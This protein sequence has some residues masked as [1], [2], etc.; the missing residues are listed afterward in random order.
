MYVQ[1]KLKMK[2]LIFVGVI[3]ICCFCKLAESDCP[4]NDFECDSGACIKS[5]LVC[6]GRPD[7][8][9]N[10]DENIDC[11]SYLCRP[12]F[13]YKCKGDTIACIS[14]ST[15]CDNITD[16]PSGDDEHNCHEYKVYHETRKCTEYEFTCDDKMCISLD[17]I[18]NGKKDCMDNS[19]EV[20]GC[21]SIETT[22]KGFLCHNKHCLES[23]EWVCDGQDDCGDNSD[24][25]NCCKLT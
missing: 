23:H 10:S 13:W 8:S 5:D 3:I 7:C 2:E 9:D 17:L 21:L 1:Q 12:P 25:D 4:I 19:D 16:C 24:E 20:R 11:D 14:D 18:C 15:R 22:C 6:D